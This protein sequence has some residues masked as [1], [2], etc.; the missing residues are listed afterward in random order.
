MDL[1]RAHVEGTVNCTETIFVGAFTAREAR[2]DSFYFV[3]GR[4]DGTFDLYSTELKGELVLSN[5]HFRGRPAALDL[6]GV[7]VGTQAYLD[8]ARFTGKLDAVGLSVEEQFSFNKIICREDVDFY[9]LSVKRG[10]FIWESL[11]RR[12]FKFRSAS[13]SGDFFLSGSRFRGDA[14]FDGSSFSTVVMAADPEHGSR[15]TKFRGK[16]SFTLSRFSQLGFQGV[17]CMSEN[18]E[19][20]FRQMVVVGGVVFTGARFR[21]KVSFDSSSFGGEA[22]FQLVRF[23]GIKD[24]G[25]SGAVFHSTAHFEGATFDAGVDFRLARFEEGAIF[26]A[27]LK[28]WACFDMCRF[29]GVADFSEQ[30]SSVNPDSE[31]SFDCQEPPF[32]CGTQF[33]GVSFTNADFA[34]DARFEN[35]CFGQ[36]LD[37]RE[38]SFS[39]LYLPSDPEKAYRLLPSTLDLRGCTYKQISVA[40]KPLLQTQD[41]EARLQPNE[42]SPYNQLERTLRSADD[43][44]CADEVHLAGRKIQRK[45][46]FSQ[47]LWIEWLG[48]CVYKFVANYGIRPYRLAAVSIVLIVAATIFFGQPEAIKRKQKDDSGSPIHVVTLTQAFWVS[49]QQ[50]LPISLPFGDVYVPA[51][52]PIEL[53]L[54]WKRLHVS[55]RTSPVEVGSI[56]KIFGWILVPLGVAAL[57]GVL[58]R[59]PT[60]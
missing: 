17:H 33:A 41:G 31:L 28:E 40:V 42:R 15:A 53:A 21:G 47:K 50:F 22:W 16:V 3:D 55:V 36:H 35:V 9:E 24:V 37:L 6:S 27:L 25:F 43:H 56:L 39:T 32:P 38:C 54:P 57:S 58:R 52:T 1:Q 8:G 51:D 49:L 13:I 4:A 12:T 7:R 23:E 11:F 26:R 34:S 19:T 18:E 10:C 60:H 59:T 44:K 45:Q 5:S 14:L 48:S 46:Y 20:S 2:F 30:E 29:R